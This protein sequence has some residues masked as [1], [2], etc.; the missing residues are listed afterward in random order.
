MKSINK[1][2]MISS[3]QFVITYMKL[4]GDLDAVSSDLGQRRNVVKQRVNRMRRAGVKLPLK[5]QGKGY[6]VRSL[7]ELIKSMRGEK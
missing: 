5:M 6:D 3:E 7:N 4:G 2:R 1:E